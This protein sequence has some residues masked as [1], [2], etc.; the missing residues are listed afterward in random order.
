MAKIKPIIVVLGL[1]SL[2]GIIHG[3]ILDSFNLFV[4]WFLI[5]LW[6]IFSFK[7]F[8]NIKRYRSFNSPHNT[9]FFVIEPLFVGIFYSIWGYFT[10]LFG[11]QHCIM[12]SN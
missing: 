3:I 11:G 2:I 1:F 10:G 7:V 12:E 8:K 4:T 9:A 5:G 6:L